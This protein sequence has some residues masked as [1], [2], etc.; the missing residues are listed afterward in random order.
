MRGGSAGFF[1]EA[2]KILRRKSEFFPI[3]LDGFG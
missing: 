1:V 2:M 3:L